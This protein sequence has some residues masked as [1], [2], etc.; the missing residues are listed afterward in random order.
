M[1]LVF[2]DEYDSSTHRVI[3]W[4]LYCKKPFIRINEDSTIQ[5]EKIVL[6]NE[7]LD[8]VLIIDVPTTKTSVQ[9]KSSDITGYWYRRG[10][11]NLKMPPLINNWEEL[12]TVFEKMKTYNHFEN[13]KIKDFFHNYFSH[14]H[15]LGCYND[16]YSINKMYNLFRAQKLKILIPESLSVRKKMDLESFIDKHSQCI[17]KGFDRNSFNIQKSVGVGNSATLI[18]KENLHNLPQ[19]FGYSFVQQYIDKKADIR[20]FYIGEKIFST[21]IFSQNDEQTKVDFRNYNEEKPNRIQPFKL[22]ISEE[23]KLNKLMQALHYKTGSIDYVLD[24]NNAFYFLEINP[25]GQYGFIS[26]ACNL[27]LDKTIVNYFY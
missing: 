18:N 13:G 11:F 7:K 26:A 17:L 1:L 27:H 9:V 10:Y 21:A 15:S 2:S 5:V 6:D 12:E 8:F 24:K 20:V 16:N 3:D 4:L 19:D 23:I 25:V 14:I 22:P